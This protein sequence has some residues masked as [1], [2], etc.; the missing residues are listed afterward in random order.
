MKSAVRF[1]GALCLAASL[2]ISPHGKAQT[3]TA[4]VLKVETVW[5]KGTGTMHYADELRLSA[6]ASAP[7]ALKTDP[8]GGKLI[9]VP[10]PQYPVDDTHVLLLGWSSYGGGM[11]TLH[12]LL[13]HLENGNV[14]L[15]RELTLTTARTVSALIVRRD[16]P[17]QIRLGIGEPA[18]RMLSE[19]DWLLVFG[20]DSDQRLDV[21][22]I[23]KLAFAA[24]AKREADA[25]Y[26]PPSQNA[27]FP[28]RAA[29]F[30]VS[31]SGFAPVAGGR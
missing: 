4:P 16:G 21:A 30:S 29:W 9:P 17:N 27:Q 23:R 18:A 5:P 22:Q 3:G 8:G 6:G 14:A 24:E 31:A 2:L 10:G 26:A 20:P 13:L 28:A 12:A 25:L 11:Q 15:Q 7:L 19:R 1:A